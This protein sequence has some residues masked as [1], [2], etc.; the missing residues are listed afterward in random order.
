MRLRT[1]HTVF[2]HVTTRLCDSPDVWRYVAE[3]EDALGKNTSS[4]DALGC[5]RQAATM[6]AEPL[7]IGDTD[8]GEKAAAVQE[9]LVF[10]LAV[11]MSAVR[12]EERNVETRGRRK[13]R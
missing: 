11:M 5:L 7:G 8:G 1:A 13:K 6:A 4:V 9:Q 2:D 12:N 3:L 10:A